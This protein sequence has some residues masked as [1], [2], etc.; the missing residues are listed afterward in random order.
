[1]TTNLIGARVRG[2]IHDTD[3]VAHQ[4]EGE[5]AALEAQSSPPHGPGQPRQWGCLVRVDPGGDAP[6]IVHPLNAVELE[7]L[8]DP[9]DDFANPDDV[10]HSLAAEQ[11]RSNGLD[12]ECA[13]LTLANK[14]LDETVAALTA[15]IEKLRAASADV[16]KLEVALAA[17]ADERETL[18][19]EIENLREKL[20]AATMSKPKKT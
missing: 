12:E 7:F 9:A 1:M 4:F 15:E 16:K 17:G 19:E 3:G 5:L 11:R 18:S 20:R 13:R 8:P 14:A 6:A 2:T 10:W